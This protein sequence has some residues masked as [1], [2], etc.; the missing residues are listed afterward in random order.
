LGI[1]HQEKSGNPD[2]TNE[3]LSVTVFEKLPK[4]IPM[5]SENIWPKSSQNL[6][7]ADTFVT[8]CFQNGVISYTMAKMSFQFHYKVSVSL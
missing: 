1:R 6:V 2:V 5:Y 7:L 3:T 8:K 4:L